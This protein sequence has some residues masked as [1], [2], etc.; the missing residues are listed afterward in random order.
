M[1]R[2]VWNVHSEHDAA[3]LLWVLQKG[4]RFNACWH[5]MHA[6]CSFSFAGTVLVQVSEQVAK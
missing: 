4:R 1:Q 2:I 6:V 3:D 5:C